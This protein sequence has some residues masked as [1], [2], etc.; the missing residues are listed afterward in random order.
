MTISLATYKRQGVR[1]KR[2]IRIPRSIFVD[3]DVP[4][5]LTLTK[6]SFQAAD[7][8]SV[9]LGLGWFVYHKPTLYLDN[10]D[11]YVGPDLPFSLAG[12]STKSWTFSL[13][14]AAERGA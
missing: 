11:S 7:V 2:R 10:Q 13:A 14:N 3:F 4:L 5:T 8:E 1:I 9:V 6:R 12:N